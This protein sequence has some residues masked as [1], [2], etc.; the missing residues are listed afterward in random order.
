VLQQRGRDV[1]ASSADYTSRDDHMP[2]AQVVH[3]QGVAGRKAGR[4]GFQPIA[5]ALATLSADAVREHPNML[6]FD[7]DPGDGVAWEF[8]SETAL[9][10]PRMLK[11]E[12]F[13]PWPKLTRVRGCTSSRR[14]IG[15]ST[16]T[17]KQFAQC[18]AVSTPDR[19]L[20]NQL[21]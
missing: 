2:W 11:D 20:Q 14:L 12:G 15:C 9:R 17:A 7:L 18:L 16:T 5:D 1:G 3:P 21:P 4:G 13:E 19:H 6:V 10:L 8:V